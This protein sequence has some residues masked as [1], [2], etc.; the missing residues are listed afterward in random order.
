MQ[1][2]RFIFGVESEAGPV[3]FVIDHSSSMAGFYFDS[4]RR[5]LIDSV[6]AMGPGQKFNVFL[7]NDQFK[8]F[9]NGDLVLPLDK[10]KHDFTTWINAVV[11]SGGTNPV[12]AFEKAAQSATNTIFLLSDGEFGFGV[13]DRIIEL[14]N[15][16]DVVVHTFSF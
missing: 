12:P 9:R 2:A 14:A 1:T 15:Q 8:T 13:A 10:N 7:Y 6:T 3:S 16:Y 11:P 5:Q 4:A